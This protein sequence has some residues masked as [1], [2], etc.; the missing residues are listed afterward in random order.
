MFPVLLT[1]LV[2]STAAGISA[3]ILTL[4]M[5]ADVSD[6]YEFE[7][8][9]K[10]EGLFS[11]GMFFMQKIVNGIG[12]L[13][14]G[15]IIALVGLPS[16]AGAGTVDGVIV[17]NLALSYLVIAT[18]ISLIGAWAY[19]LFPLGENEHAIREAHRGGGAAS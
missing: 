12:I 11:S 10:T 9:R 18:V 8:G 2:A 3:M 1:F 17:D 6:H 13:L 5:I 14:S 15:L 7:T 19:T 16:G 4:S